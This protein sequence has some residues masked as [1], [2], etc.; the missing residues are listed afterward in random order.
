M[1][2]KI[3]AYIIVA[4]LVGSTVGYLINQI[5]NEPKITA[6]QTTVDNLSADIANLTAS[7]DTL[8]SQNTV[9]QESVRSLSNQSLVNKTV[10]TGYLEYLS[11]SP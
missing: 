9:L 1:D 2:P 5:L 11:Q 6:L 3:L 4:L 10:R 7:L 8:K